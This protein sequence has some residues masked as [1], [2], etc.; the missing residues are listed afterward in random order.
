MRSLLSNEK[1]D[2][3]YNPDTN[4]IELIWKKY[5]DDQTYKLM[6]NKGVECLKE[7]G[8]TGWLSD[9]RQEGVVGPASSRWLQQT[10]IPQAISYGLKKIAI[11][12]DSD[13]FK[14]FYVQNIEKQTSHQLIKHFDS[15][16]TAQAWLREN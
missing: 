5:Q 12:M 2:L 4:S 13:V 1:A 6:F 11:V 8:A 7:F 15:L 16:S 3:L 14:K 9:I 10:I